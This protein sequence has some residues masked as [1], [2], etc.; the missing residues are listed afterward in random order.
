M[1][2]PKSYYQ[3]TKPS[4]LHL[5]TSPALPTIKYQAPLA[6][7]AP[8][9]AS[10][11]TGYG[12]VLGTTSHHCGY[13]PPKSYQTPL[14]SSSPS[15]PYRIIPL[16][17][18]VPP[19]VPSR[20]KEHRHSTSLLQER[21]VTLFGHVPRLSSPTDTP[22]T[23]SHVPAT[24][25]DP[26][27]DP[28]VSDLAARVYIILARK[29]DATRAYIAAILHRST[30][31]ISRAFAALSK[32]RYLS[33]KEQPLPRNINPHIVTTPSEISALID[34]TV[35]PRIELLQA[36]FPHLDVR[37]LF[38][39]FS[40]TCTSGTGSNPSPNPYKYR[41]FYL[42]FRQWCRRAVPK[43]KQ[44]RSHDFIQSFLN[45]HMENNT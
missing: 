30:R 23:S 24:H 32:N 31:T 34:A 8:F 29:P 37:Q 9:A 3:L 2:L 14:T 11:K 4:I 17:P 19:S 6:T 45:K 13:C 18:I 12:F 36:E 27:T 41:D 10:I 16:P 5:R 15:A 25:R 28:D 38:D 22:H 35:A 26:I 21:F 42:A 33:R 1:T 40:E 43:T 44:P 20:P 7:A 39:H